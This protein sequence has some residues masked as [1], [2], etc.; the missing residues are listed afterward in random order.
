MT[1]AF[2]CAL[3]LAS[4]AAAQVQPYG[5]ND[6]GGFRSILPPGRARP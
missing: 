3:L 2:A 4:P 6:Y 1:L 5:T